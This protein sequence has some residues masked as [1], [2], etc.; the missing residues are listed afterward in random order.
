MGKSFTTSGWGTSSIKVVHAGVI[1]NITTRQLNITEAEQKDIEAGKD[2]PLDAAVAQ[3]LSDG[4]K[5]VTKTSQNGYNYK[6]VVSREEL[7]LQAKMMA[8]EAI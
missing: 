6:V 5:I 7:K 3:A 4:F 8:D 1:L 2:V